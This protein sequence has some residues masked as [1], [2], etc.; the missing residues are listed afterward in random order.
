MQ[1]GIMTTESK[2][3]TRE[4]YWWEAEKRRSPRLNYLRKS[5][6]S[7]N[8]IQSDHLPGVMCGLDKVYWYTK[9]FATGHGFGVLSSTGQ[10]IALGPRSTG[11]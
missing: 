9:V 4:A 11:T 8:C 5:I 10:K 1:E 3:T 6:W 7:K 2:E